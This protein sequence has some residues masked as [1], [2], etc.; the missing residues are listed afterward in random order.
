MLARPKHDPAQP[1]LPT[2][3][4]SGVLL[5]RINPSSSS[6]VWDATVMVRALAE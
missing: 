6:R 3:Y 4:L 1:D 2:T 5:Y